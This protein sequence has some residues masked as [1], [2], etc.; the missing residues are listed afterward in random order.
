MSGTGV[1]LSSGRGGSMTVR[2]VHRWVEH[3]RCWAPPATVRVRNGS[4]RLGLSMVHGLTTVIFRCA[5]DAC[6][7]LQTIEAYGPVVEAPRP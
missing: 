4:E 2:H 7:E 1:F 3:V 6:G 5:H